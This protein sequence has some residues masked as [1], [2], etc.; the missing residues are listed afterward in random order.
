MPGNVELESIRP[1]LSAIASRPCPR[2]IR[3]LAPSLSKEARRIADVGCGF[4]K[5][6]V[7][8]LKHH[9]K[10]YAVDLASQRSRIEDRIRNCDA[11]EGFAGF[12]TFEEFQQ[13][14]LRLGG[15]Y[16]VNVLHT[17]PE[18]EMRVELLRAVHANLR[19]SGFAVLD[20]PSSAAYYTG[21]M[22]D[23]NRY[24]DG[25]IFAQGNGFYTFY[26]FTRAQELDW[27]AAEA[28]FRFDF[29]VTVHNHRVT[30]Y[31]R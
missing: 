30:V 24:G 18:V 29:S 15:A 13:S 27:W 25:F 20:V 26:R 17:L 10:V 8:L 9:E 14:K 28:G 3:L 1:E 22:T 16:V 21:R 6:T 5:G 4:M 2:S 12:K 23:K 7:D 11:Y 19:G 31:R